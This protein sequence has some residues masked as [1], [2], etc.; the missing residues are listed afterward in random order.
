MLPSF[1]ILE[2][3]SLL[4][5][6]NNEAPTPVT[7]PQ[8]FIASAAE[9]TTG[10]KYCKYSFYEQDD[11]FFLEYRPTPTS[12][13]GYECGFFLVISISICVANPANASSLSYPIFK[14]GGA[15]RH[16]LWTNTSQDV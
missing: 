12:V 6:H 4:K 10:V 2:R 9:F 16:Y 8:N 14:Q 5:E 13:I 15:T 3:L 1:K 11:L 7:S